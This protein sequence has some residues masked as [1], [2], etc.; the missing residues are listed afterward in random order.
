MMM[1]PGRCT[2]EDR[3]GALFYPPMMSAVERK[4]T[5]FMPCQLNAS[6]L[7]IARSAAS[8]GLMLVILGELCGAHTP[9][10]RS[11]PVV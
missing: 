6:M 9:A 7:L 11:H 10:L 2:L 1:P 8:A 5:M 4:F 3:E